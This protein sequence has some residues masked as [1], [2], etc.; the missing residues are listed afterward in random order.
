MKAAACA[1]RHA[2]VHSCLTPPTPPTPWSRRGGAAGRA[3]HCGVGL[4]ADSPGELGHVHRG[5]GPER[6]FHQGEEAPW[7]GDTFGAARR[8]AI[9]M[10][11]YQGGRRR[12]GGPAFPGC[13]GGVGCVEE[14][15]RG[16]GAGPGFCGLWASTGSSVQTEQ[17]PAL[18]P[19][20]PSTRAALLVSTLGSRPLSTHH[21]GPAQCAALCHFAAAKSVAEGAEAACHRPIPPAFARWR[22]M[23]SV[24]HPPPARCAAPRSA[25]W[26]LPPLSSMAVSR[27]C[28]WK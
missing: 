3:S 22:L 9:V 18:Q 6:N 15:G 23:P 21:R 8:G 13:K 16:T 17:A 14:K 19:S 24:T 27:C 2:G 4:G 26:T 28:C 1:P 7:G 11:K 25:P 20:H 10:R 5:H 12:G